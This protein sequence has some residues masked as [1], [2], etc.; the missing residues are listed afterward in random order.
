MGCYLVWILLHLCTHF[1]WRE[2]VWTCEVCQ[3]DYEGQRTTYRRIFLLPP[4]KSKLRAQ[5]SKLGSW[6]LYSEHLPA[7]L[8][9]LKQN[10]M[11]ELLEWS[12]CYWL[13]Y[14]GRHSSHEPVISFPLCALSHAQ[15]GFLHKM[16]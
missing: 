3:S 12:C 14:V 5:D 15:C 1:F 2:G 8:V 6:H 13:V 10:N 4:C 7:P 9:G 16:A 11:V